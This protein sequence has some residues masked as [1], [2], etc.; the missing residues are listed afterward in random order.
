MPATAQQTQTAVYVKQLIPYGEFT[1]PAYPAL[2]G[3]TISFTDR[4]FNKLIKNFR[5]GV[6]GIVPIPK[7]H[8][9]SV[10]SNTGELEDLFVV[11][12]EPNPKHNGLYGRL[13][14]KDGE[15]NVRIADG[16]FPDVS[17]SLDD[18]FEDSYGNKHGWT[19]RH[20]ALVSQP[21][22]PDMKGF[23]RYNQA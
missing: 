21:H 1:N 19:M 13:K 2:G 17:V 22:L 16:R 7:D 9:D 5:K 10:E 14:I 6:L 3:P 12:N 4:I 18:N 20:V 11:K 15:T 23:L 8:T